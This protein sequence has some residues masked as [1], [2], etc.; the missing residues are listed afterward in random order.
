[1]KRSSL[2]TS[3]H[4]RG[5]NARP[6]RFTPRLT[7]LAALL[8]AAS[9]TPV[10]AQQAPSAGDVLRETTRPLPQ[11]P[12]A[13]PQLPRAQEVRPALQDKA[14]FKLAVNGFRI[15]GNKAI[16]E[17]D[18][19]LLL[20]DNLG[21]ENTFA[22]LQAAADA[23][24]NYYRSKG[25]FV[26]RA[27]LPQQE[28]AGGIV[29]IAVLE[30]T[31]GQ[32]VAKVGG[33]ARTRPEVVQRILDANVPPGA[34]V[35]EKAL[36]RAALLANDLPGM[37]ASVTLDPGTQTGQTDVTLNAE[38]GKL[39]GVT[40]D[41]D[42]Y[43]NAYTGQ[44]R[45]GG[46]AYLNSPLGLGDQL[47]LRVMKSNRELEFAR[48]NY[49]LPINGL[50]TRLGA[51]WS[52]VQ[53]E[54]CCQ[55]GLTPSGSGRI[56]T[57]YA[58]H[59][60][61]RSRNFSAYLN[62]SYDDKESVNDAGIGAARVRDIGL[63]T[64]AGSVEAR[65]ELLGGGFSFANVSAGFGRL[66]IR[67][68]ADAGTDAAGPDAAGS[69]S[70]LGV[71][72]ARTQRLSDRLSLYGGLNGQ[73]ASKNLDAAEKF[74]LGGAQG[75]RGYP[76]GEAAG[77]NGY[78][79]QIELRA[80]LPLEVMG[81]QWQAFVFYDHGA[82]TVNREN[83]IVAGLTPNHYSLKSWGLGLNLAKAGIFQVRAMWAHKIGENPAR[84]FVTGEDADGKKERSRVWFQAVTQF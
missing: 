49:S 23:L 69:F 71:Q 63:F 78:V 57:I 2:A 65:D 47:S 44:N 38:E 1:M 46:T 83:F 32:S 39:F 15:T 50:G 40:L 73:V 18:L 70:K 80:D 61:A 82:T 48:L 34:V 67:D 30:G 79:A 19:Q 56:A 37:A 75:V 13:E 45:V 12:K 74:S 53:F 3:L 10:F 41:A 51:S 16:P 33:T 31:V 59:P 72:L 22:Q 28:I 25:Y 7:V 64:I 68:A 8:A 36:E 5:K 77:D 4:F 55:V 60:L 84:N 66:R 9:V 42:N 35:H 14:G 76:S 58:V 21:K 43:G 27:Y 26:A 29:E 52:K 54:V 81:T 20:L 6:A 62:A 11:A 24:S 17:N